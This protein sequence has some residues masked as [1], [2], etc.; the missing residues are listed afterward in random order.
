MAIGPRGRGA[1]DVTELALEVELARRRQL[2]ERDLSARAAHLRPADDERRGAA[3]VADGHRAPVLAHRGPAR[4]EDPPEVRR[5]LE[6]R[7]EVDVVGD[8]HREHSL[9]IGRRQARGRW[10]RPV[11]DDLRASA[12]AARPR[13]GSELDQRVEIRLVQ[14]VREVGVRSRAAPPSRG[15]RARSRRRRRARPAARVRRR[16]DARRPTA[17]ATR[18]ASPPTYARRH[19]RPNA[20]WRKTQGAHRPGCTRLSSEPGQGPRAFDGLPRVNPG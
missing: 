15:S 19:I 8:A 11:R 16:A 18:S 14:R 10:H 6:R 17:G 7:V 4:P 9:P 3:V 20:R 12:R 1:A 13:R 5:V 2:A